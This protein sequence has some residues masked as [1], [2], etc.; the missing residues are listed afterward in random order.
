[1]AK[2]SRE[3]AFE[4]IQS[5]IE[6]HGHHIY[7]VSREGAL[8]RFAYTI[9]LS[10]SAGFELLLPGAI[11]FNAEDVVR[12]INAMAAAVGKDSNASTA[13][14]SLASLGSFTLREV[15]P[16]WPRDL[17]LG[18]FDF[19]NVSSLPAFQIIPDED[20]WSLDIPDMGKPWSAAAN[21]IWQWLEAPWCFPVPATSIASTNL[22]ALRGER[23]TEAARW[24]EDNWEIFAGDGSASYD[25][26]RVVALGTLLAIDESLVAVTR[27]AVDEGICRNAEG[28]IGSLG[29]EVH[30]DRSRLRSTQRCPSETPTC[31]VLKGGRASQ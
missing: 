30:F 1:M 29:N 20:H 9:G 22:A 13:R 10:L 17:M 12:I 25:D 7:I 24:G 15:H 27:L 8:P 5:H 28:G 16:S 21:P 23:V 4:A 11:T 31:S 19:F 6:T 14:V 3:A 26:M 18:A 2:N